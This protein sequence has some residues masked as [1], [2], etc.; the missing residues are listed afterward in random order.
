MDSDI[1]VLLKHRFSTEKETK[2]RAG[3]VVD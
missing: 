2:Y 1:K 3:F